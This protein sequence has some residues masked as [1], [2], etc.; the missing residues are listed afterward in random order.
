M[1]QV[2]LCHFDQIWNQ[3]ITAFQ[4]HI[5]LRERILEAVAQL[6]QPVVHPHCIQRDHHHAQQQHSQNNPHSDH[7]YF[8][9]F[10]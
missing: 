6:H 3:V 10:R 4:L 7:V 5:D 9:Q 2:L 1:A 8:L